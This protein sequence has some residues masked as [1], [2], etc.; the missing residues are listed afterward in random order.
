MVMGIVY[1]VTI[2]N[3]IEKAKKADKTA[4]FWL[5]SAMKVS[6]KLVM[7]QRFVLVHLASEQ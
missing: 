4:L 5:Y 7:T 6:A 3:A 1:H 2:I